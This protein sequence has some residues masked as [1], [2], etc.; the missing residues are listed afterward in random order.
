M[1]R[2]QQ[3][4]TAF[5]AAFIGLLRNPHAAFICSLLARSL[6]D[7]LQWPLLDGA[8]RIVARG[9]TKAGSAQRQAEAE[10]GLKPNKYVAARIGC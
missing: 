10:L 8:L 6:F 4:D 2:R 1:E 7:K 9:D 3:D 5:Y